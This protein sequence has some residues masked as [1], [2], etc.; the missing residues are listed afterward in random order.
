MHSIDRSNIN[1]NIQLYESK[2]FSIEDVIFDLD[3]IEDKNIIVYMYKHLLHK[4][5]TKIPYIKVRMRCLNGDY[6]TIGINRWYFYNSYKAKEYWKYIYRIIK[7]VTN[8]S[9]I[10]I[11]DNLRDCVS[12]EKIERFYNEC[13]M[14]ILMLNQLKR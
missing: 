5:H 6:M 12:F 10:N 2:F 7:A 13:F 9:G 11:Q 14:L 1:V 3:Y 8:Q 4:K